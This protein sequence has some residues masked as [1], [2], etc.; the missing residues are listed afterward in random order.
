MTN[1]TKQNDSTEQIKQSESR[2]DE[3]CGYLFSA[4]GVL[5]GIFAIILI[6]FAGIRYNEFSNLEKTTCNV[7]DIAYPT[8]SYSNSS[9]NW[10][11][12]MCKHGPCNKVYA[13]S[14]K[15]CPILYTNLEENKT[16]QIYQTFGYGKK[17]NKIVAP[18]YSYSPQ[19]RCSIKSFCD[20]GTNNTERYLEFAQN[21]YNEY[22]HQN[23][24]CYIDPKTNN[25]YMNKQYDYTSTII[26][27]VVLTLCIACVFLQ[28]LLLIRKN[29]RK[30]E[31]NKVN[32]YVVINHLYKN[33]LDDQ[34]F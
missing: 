14:Y 22:Y 30:Q 26:G 24:V 34:I 6:I 15:P 16:S 19:Q 2:N 29:R 13:Y 21:V 18:W 12:C 3:Y 10:V 7:I 5:I 20:C 8:V 11:K 23:I 4:F 33:E 25:I 27:F 17:C 28:Q 32:Q 9:D 1:E 31:M